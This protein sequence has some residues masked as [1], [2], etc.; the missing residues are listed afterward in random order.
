MSK[1]SVTAAAG[2]T[3]RLMSLYW[4]KPADDLPESRA[5]PPADLSQAYRSVKWRV[6]RIPRDGSGAAAP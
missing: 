3:D 1:T 6:Q 5:V 4:R 2:F